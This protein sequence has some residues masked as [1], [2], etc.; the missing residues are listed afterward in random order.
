LSVGQD[1]FPGLETDLAARPEHFVADAVGHVREPRLVER[2][3]SDLFGIEAAIVGRND[4]VP[5]DG[6]GQLG[7]GVHASGHDGIQVH[8]SRR[9]DRV[10]VG[11]AREIDIAERAVRNGLGLNGRCPVQCCQRQRE[12]AGDCTDEC[13]LC[14]ATRAGP[15]TRTS[16]R[17]LFRIWTG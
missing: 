14:R 13:G 4:M 9:I 10:E 6:V 16:A 12:N 11:G 8:R 7:R 1:G 17:H 5:F 15:A 2:F 3:D